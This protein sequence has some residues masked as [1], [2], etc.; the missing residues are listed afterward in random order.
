[1]QH[2]TVIYARGH[3]LGGW[4]IRHH[5]DGARRR[6]SHSGVVLGGMVVESRWRGGVQCT[7]I[8]AFERRYSRTERVVYLVPDIDG[9]ADWVRMQI[10]KPYDWHAALGRAL[11]LPLDEQGA[12]HCHELCE[13]YLAACG[14]ARWRDSPALITP[15]A[16]FS[17][18]AGVL[19]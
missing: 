2:A 8:E 16:G 14:I 18:L 4:L 11:R 1:M 15:N 3:T 10:G 9:G 12:W 17:N 19:Q 13:A 5:D 6:W 7:S